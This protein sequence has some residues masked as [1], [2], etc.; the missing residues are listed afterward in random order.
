SAQRRQQGGGRGSRSALASHS[1]LRLQT[2]SS[3]PPPPPPPPPHP[4]PPARP[5]AFLSPLSL[6]TGRPGSISG[7]WV[8]GIDQGRG[9]GSRWLRR[10]SWAASLLRRGPSPAAFVASPCPA[11]RSVL[12]ARARCRPDL[13]PG[14]ALLLLLLR[15]GPSSVPT[16]AGKREAKGRPEPGP[17]WLKSAS[18]NP[19]CRESRKDI[20]RLLQEKELQEEKKRKK[21][22]PESPGANA[23]GDSYYYEDGDQPRSRRARELGSGFSKSYRPQSEEKTVKQRKE[24]SKHPQENLEE[25]EEHCSSEKP[26]SSSSLGKVRDDPQINTEQP[27][28]KQSGHERPRRPPLPKI[29][30]EVFLST[31]SEDW[32][33]NHSHRTRNWEKQSRHQDQ[34]SPEASQKAGLHCKE[35]VYRSDHG[36]GEHRERKHRPRAPPFSESEERH[37]LRDA[38][39]KPRVMKEAVSTPSRVTNRNQEW[40]DAEIARKLQ[41]EEILATQVDMRAAQVAQDE[42]IARLLMAEEKKAYKKAREREKSSVDKRKH[43]PEWKPKTAKSAY[44]KSKDSDEPHHSKNDRPARP[45]PPT[46]TEAEDLDYTHFT[47]QHNSTRHFSKSESSHKDR[48]FCSITEDM[49]DDK[50]PMLSSRWTDA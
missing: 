39:T 1:Q 8:F 42:E 38:G 2:C 16:A 12:R 29:S 30:G 26:L 46:M 14:R 45:L 50:V 15:A 36:Q 28:R 20:A 9:R 7:L 25:L 23:Y 43:D 22:F 10:G 32:E 19:S 13:A 27:E 24:K 17:T 48:L 40:Y 11:A 37:Q 34:L 5:P 41:E 47:N 21:H 44:S 33:T 31:E 6:R 49:N 3:P 35:A 4:G 18:T